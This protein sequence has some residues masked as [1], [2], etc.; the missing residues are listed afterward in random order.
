M[1]VNADVLETINFFVSATQFQLECAGEGTR[2]MLPL[3]WSREAPIREAVTVAYERL[4]A[5]LAAVPSKAGA[6]HVAKN[7]IALTEG[8]TLAVRLKYSHV[9]LREN[10]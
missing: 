8:A 4:Y 5:N 2:K 1:Q 3:I 6:M 7:L 10:L 9:C